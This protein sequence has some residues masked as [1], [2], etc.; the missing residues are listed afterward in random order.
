[1]GCNVCNMRRSEYRY[2]VADPT[3]AIVAFPHTRMVYDTDECGLER[4][5]PVHTLY[6]L[7]RGGASAARA[8]GVPLDIIKAF[9]GWATGSSAL[10]EHYLDLGVRGCPYAFGFFSPLAA[11]RVAPVAGQFFNR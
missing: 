3:I 11:R 8:A 4:L 2:S 7:R 6:S 9:G 1:N 5:R 10:R